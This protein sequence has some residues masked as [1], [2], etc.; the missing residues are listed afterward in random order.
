MLAVG[1][2][3]DAAWWLMGNILREWKNKSSWWIRARFGSRLRY[4]NVNCLNVAFYIP[5]M[6][7]GNTVS[8]AEEGF[9][10]A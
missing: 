5:I 10:S 3:T 6:V 8:E 4:P 2:G 7:N 1:N 9:G